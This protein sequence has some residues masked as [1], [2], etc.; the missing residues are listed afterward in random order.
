MARQRE[1]LFHSL[2]LSGA[3]EFISDLITLGR[4]A[5][6]AIL[7]A[8]QRFFGRTANMTPTQARTINRVARMAQRM[9]VGPESLKQMLPI[10]RVPQYKMPVDPTIPD[11][12]RYILSVR[13]HCPGQPDVYRTSVWDFDFNPN[14]RELENLI[15]DKR[16]KLFKADSP[17]MPPIVQECTIELAAIRG[18]YRRS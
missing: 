17:D 12:F 6:S 15:K 13:I 4:S 9:I 8:A 7:S 1:T 3:V 11:R 2:M 14:R 10:S 16:E 18:T 5:G